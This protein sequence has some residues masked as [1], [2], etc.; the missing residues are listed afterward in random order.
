MQSNW[1][2]RFMFWCASINE[3]SW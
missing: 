1:V 2:L 3:W